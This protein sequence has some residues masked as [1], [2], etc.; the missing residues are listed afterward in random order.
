MHEERCS[1]IQL[2]WCDG[3]ECVF[4]LC[5]LIVLGVETYLVKKSEPWFIAAAAAAATATQR[6]VRPISP[7]ERVLRVTAGFQTSM[8]EGHLRFGNFLSSKENTRRTT[9][10]VF[11][12]E[13]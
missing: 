12:I 9:E 11:F 3:L 1:D 7:H 2:W 8:T 6:F 5:H 13:S 4:L 10:A